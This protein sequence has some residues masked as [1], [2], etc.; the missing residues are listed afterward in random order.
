MAL[1]HAIDA[2]CERLGATEWVLRVH[3]LDAKDFGLPQSLPRVYITGRRRSLVDARV[4]TLMPTQFEA[5]PVCLAEIMDPS[6]PAASSYESTD[7]Q[8]T[9]IQEHKDE[10]RTCM[11]DPRNRGRLAVC[12]SSRSLRKRWGGTYRIDGLCMCLTTRNKDLYVFALG[13]GRENTA[14]SHDRYISMNERC[15]LH[16]VSPAAGADCAGSAR[17][18]CAACPG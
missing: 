9:V 5:P 6:L 13:E 12:S 1:D 14:L 10:L 8:R 7:Y 15:L 4:T 16:G 17:E 3:K 18:P 2:L 11:D